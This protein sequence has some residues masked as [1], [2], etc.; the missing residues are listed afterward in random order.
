MRNELEVKNESHKNRNI[1]CQIV[2]ITAFWV[3]L[4]RH[5]VVSI[6]LKFIVCFMKLLSLLSSI[7]FNWVNTPKPLHSSLQEKKKL[8]NYKSAFKISFTWL[9]RGVSVWFSWKKFGPFECVIWNY[10]ELIFGCGSPGTHSWVLSGV[11]LHKIPYCKNSLITP[12]ILPCVSRK[13]QFKALWE[14]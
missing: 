9:W 1:L 5:P 6:K 3:D 7:F 4:N 2:F 12:C 13:Q 8:Q 14:V 11:F 10:A